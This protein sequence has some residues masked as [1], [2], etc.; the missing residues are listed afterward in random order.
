[1]TA[2]DEGVPSTSPMQERE[3]D[4]RFDC[5]AFARPPLVLAAIGYSP[6]AS[7][8][9]VQLQVVA[10]VAAAVCLRSFNKHVASPVMN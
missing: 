7:Y 6:V 3:T 4:G 9:T 10:R 8:C 5:A 2:D 1:M